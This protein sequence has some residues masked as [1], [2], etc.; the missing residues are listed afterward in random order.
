MKNIPEKKKAVATS[1]EDDTKSDVKD[2][3]EPQAKPAPTP[4]VA[5][6]QKGGPLTTRL[7][8]SL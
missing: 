7:H 2:K 6:G 1:A 8:M 4:Q 3:A 5:G